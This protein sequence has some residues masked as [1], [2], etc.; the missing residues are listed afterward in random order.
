MLQL[1]DPHLLSATVATCS[2]MSHEHHQSA[3]LG[4]PGWPVSLGAI[5]RAVHCNINACYSG[6]RQIMWCGLGAGSSDECSQFAHVC[7]SAIIQY[8]IMLS[9]NRITRSAPSH[10]DDDAS[11]AAAA[12]AAAAARGVQAFL[13]ACMHACQS[14]HLCTSSCP[15]SLGWNAD[16]CICT[17]DCSAGTAAPFNQNIHQRV[18]MVCD[19]TK[20]VRQVLTMPKASWAENPQ[21]PNMAAMSAAFITTIYCSSCLPRN[22]NDISCQDG[23]CMWDVADNCSEQLCHQQ[24]CKN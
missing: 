8:E 24:R 9:A 1:A 16:T 6:E 10:L 18:G 5:H 19:N 4:W 2:M 3:S 17:S 13:H 12:A 7:L 20:K 14:L 15:C 23:L 11:I 21:L 22:R